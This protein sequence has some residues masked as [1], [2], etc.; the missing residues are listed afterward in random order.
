MKFRSKAQTLKFLQNFKDLRIPKLLIFKEVDFLNNQQKILNT[1]SKFFVSK[2]AIRSSNVFE[3]KKNSIKAGLFKSFLNIDPI[4]K[5]EVSKSIKKVLKSYS[6]FQSKDNEFF[7]QEMVRDVKTSGVCF[8]KNIENNLPQ[9]KINYTDNQDTTLV[10]S[11]TSLVSSISF[12]DS[13][14]TNFKNFLIKKIFLIIKKIQKIVSVYDL[15]IEFI[16][17]K[18]N[19]IFIVQVRKLPQISNNLRSNFN[20]KRIYTKLEKKIIKLKKKKFKL[21]W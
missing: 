16:I 14:K 2:V 13:K 19:Q 5:S 20:I 11:G 12:L 4:N 17:N 18:K 1:I 3:D 6:N 7:I 8:T 15:D 21:T 9:W 10:T